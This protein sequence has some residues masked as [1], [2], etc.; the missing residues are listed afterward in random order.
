MWVVAVVVVVWRLRCD[1]DKDRVCTVFACERARLRVGE[2]GVREM[3]TGGEVG[4]N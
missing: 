4:R 2:L 3:E 1:G